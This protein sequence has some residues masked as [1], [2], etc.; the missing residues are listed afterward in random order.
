M[1]S[2]RSS[3]VLKQGWSF[4]QADGPANWLSVDSVPTVAHLDLIKHNVIPDPY[5]DMNELDV[6][7]VGEK[8][9]HY[10]VD[11]PEI[12]VSAKEKGSK[13][14]LV[15]EGLDTFAHVRLNGKTILL[16][17]NMFISHRV[18]I[19]D[20]VSDNNQLEIAFEPALLKARE[21]RAQHPEHKWVG[22]NADLSRLAVR[23]AQYHWGWDWGPVLMTAGPWR[24][25]HLE[26]YT[27]RVKEVR[28]DYHVADGFKSAQGTISVDTEGSAGDNVT[29][30]LKLAGQSV[31]EETLTITDGKAV[32]SFTI[33]DVSLW[34]PSGYGAQTIYTINTTVKA[35]GHELDHHTQS[36]GFRRVELVQEKDDIGRS[37]YFRINGADVFCGGS[38][39]IPADS[40]L[41]AISEERYRRWLKL[42]VDGN[43]VMVR[44][45]GGGIYE[46]DTFYNACDELGLLVWQ[47][48]MFGC[49]N[50]PTFPSFLDSVQKEAVQ[51]VR[52]LRHHPCMAIWAGNN[53][54]YQVQEQEGLEYNFDEK[55]PECWLQTNFPARY[56]Y[57]K[58]LPDVM[59]QE[60]PDVPYHP[61]SP[62]GDGKLTSDPTVGDMHQWNVWHGT[63]EK[64]QIFET[65]GGR[66]NSEF[67]M[68]AFPNI[69]TIEAFVTKKSHMYPQS[70]TLDF[71]NKADGHER[72]IA[73]YMVENFRVATELE[74]YIHLTQLVQADALMY[75]YRG[76]RRQWGQKRQCGGALVWQINDCWPGTSWAVVDYFLR[77][78][79]AYY[80]LARVLAP[81]AIGVQREHHDWSVAHAR[82]AKA[83]H[84]HLWAVNSK[85][86]PKNATVCLRFVS[87]ETGSDIKPAITKEVSLVP[88]GTTDV[89]RWSD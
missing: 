45:W 80:A 1:S 24:P 15:F 16:T 71:H 25:V 21:I 34:Y 87:I 66:F 64:H 31:F 67:G 29:V 18:D 86:E 14:V 32:A 81:I 61:G 69:Q 47:D 68:E 49:G 22:F 55:L 46:D 33:P 4:R 30:N 85:M 39:W 60:C 77:K 57:E 62:W 37:F 27:A 10:R 12:P 41:P 63:Q 35:A 40:F 54:D 20:L 9:W 42:M 78:K 38:D 74:K 76:W 70:H 17:D 26:M 48:F 5:I 75:A 7:W 88:N 19:T 44:V 28:V 83:S 89:L 65:L 23:K 73:T 13:V 36:I 82:P 11:L 51:N 50:Y 79:A 8:T 53:E 58:L 3:K 43:Q 6:E 2:L 72:R 56:I 84:F 52:R 59:S